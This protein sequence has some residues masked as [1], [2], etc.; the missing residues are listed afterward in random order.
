MKSDSG[1][2]LVV[3]L[4]VV[5]AAALVLFALSK[6]DRFMSMMPYYLRSK[7][8]ELNETPWCE[9]EPPA[10]TV[11]LSPRYA[12]G[13]FNEDRYLAIFRQKSCLAVGGKPL[14][15]WQQGIANGYW[16]LDTKFAHVFIES[17]EWV[18]KKSINQETVQL[19]GFKSVEG[20]KSAVV[21][22]GFYL[23]K[24]KIP[25]NAR[26]TLGGPIPLLTNFGAV[27]SW[28]DVKPVINAKQALLVDIRSEERFKAGHYPGAVNIPYKTEN[29]WRYATESEYAKDTFDLTKFRSDSEAKTRTLIFLIG[30]K[31]NDIE[32]YRA[33][34]R[35][36]QAGYQR[37][38]MVIGGENA[39][40]GVDDL[41]PRSIEGAKV[42]SPYDALAVLKAGAT[43]VDVRSE[44][45]EFKMPEN[46]IDSIYTNIPGLNN[47]LAEGGL[48][49]SNQKLP[50]DK[51]KSL[52]FFGEDEMDLR[53]L[54]AVKWVRALGYRNL[55]VL[56]RGI[57]GWVAHAEAEP[58]QFKV[59]RPK[60]L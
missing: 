39:R 44:K 33:M 10:D 11:M 50:A 29:H 26:R 36:R 42:I 13:G 1:F 49:F 59:I 8:A 18:P 30:Q 60:N 16:I 28:E 6:N 2:K 24:F 25:P 19:A 9:S 45:S 37:L 23:A 20:L 51:E 12:Q 5:V 21:G 41:L 56:N 15:V 31:A 35:L 17:I 55:Y 14:L 43:W 34:V 48:Y 7:A 52:V 22:G 40:I 54:S 4:I 38:V 32:P 27:M 57:M 47:Q 53:V 58:A 3:S 46:V